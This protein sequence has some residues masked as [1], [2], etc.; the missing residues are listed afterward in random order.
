MLNSLIDCSLP[1]VGGYLFGASLGGTPIHTT[2]GRVYEHIHEELD[3]LNCY[4]SS[5]TCGSAM[6]ELHRM[7]KQWIK[8][9]V[10]RSSLT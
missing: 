3:T 5:S 4:V 1:Q 8:L 2:T 6:E 9:E 10:V 7:G